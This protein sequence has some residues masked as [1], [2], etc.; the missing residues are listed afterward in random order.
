MFVNPDKQLKYNL[1]NYYKHDINDRRLRKEDDMMIEKLHDKVYMDQIKRSNMEEKMRQ[2]SEKQR[3]INQRMNDYSNFM[4]QKDEERRN[5]FVK[6]P[7]I[8]N[9]NANFNKSQSISCMNQLNS[10]NNNPYS[11]KSMNPDMTLMNMNKVKKDN[12]NHILYPEYIGVK[13]LSEIEKNDRNEYQKFYK[14][15]LDSQMNYKTSSPET[16]NNNHYVVNNMV[17]NP[18]K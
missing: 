9:E 3:Y 18:C 17:S 2:D 14:N 4:H 7:E 15:M 1:F 12:L 11:P 13:K 8:Y 16:Y 10:I 5:K 6:N